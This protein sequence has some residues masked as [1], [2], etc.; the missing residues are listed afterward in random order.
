M[1]C[2]G[3]PTPTRWRIRSERLAHAALMRYSFRMFSRP[4]F[5]PVLAGDG[6]LAEALVQQ[7]SE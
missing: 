7:M 3:V 2:F 1:A 4:G 6:G 5:Y